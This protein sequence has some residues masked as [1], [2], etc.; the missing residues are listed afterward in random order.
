MLSSMQEDREQR[1]PADGSALHT[2]ASHRGFGE[3]RTSERLCLSLLYIIYYILYI[4]Y[5][6]LYIIYYIIIVS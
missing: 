6:I 1:I 5:Y 4:I 2:G 3:H